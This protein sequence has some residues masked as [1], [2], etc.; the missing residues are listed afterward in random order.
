MTEPMSLVVERLLGCLCVCVRGE[1]MN[2]SLVGV[3]GG[4]RGGVVMVAIAVEL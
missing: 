2:S 4:W 1:M 3:A